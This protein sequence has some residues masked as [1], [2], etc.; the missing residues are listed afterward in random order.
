MIDY[1]AIL[2]RRYPNKQWTLNGE[3]YDGLVWLSDGDTPTKAELDAEWPSVQTEIENEKIT[4]ENAR[5]S[6]LAKLGL[7]A[8]EIAA[9]FG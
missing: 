1:S 6:A 4:K 3:T 9:L 5:Q 8:D 2:I 7:T